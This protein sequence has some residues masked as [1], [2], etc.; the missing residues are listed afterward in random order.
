M[1]GQ[2][3]DRKGVL[4]GKKKKVNIGSKMSKITLNAE[5]SREAND[6]KFK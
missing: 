3:R 1:R 2:I 4:R 6:V 5:K